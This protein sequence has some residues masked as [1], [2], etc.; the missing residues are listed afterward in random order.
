MISQQLKVFLQVVDCG[1]FTKAAGQLFVTPASIMKHMNTLEN[2]LGVTLLKRNNQGIS[3][4]SAG[5]ALYKDGKKLVAEAENAIFKAKNIE[6]GEGTVIRIGSSL[7]NP[8]RV[9]TDLWLPIQEKYKQYRFSIVPYEDKKEQILSVTSSL[10]ERIDILIGSFNSK[11]MLETANYYPLGHYK[12]CIAVPK[13]HPL[14]KKKELTL[15]DL[16][17]E[18]LMMVKSGDT[19]L[20]DHFHDMMKMTHPQIL[21]EEADYYYDMETF[22]TCERT[23][24]L[25]LTLDA[26]AD[27]HPFL[28]TLPV[29][30][31]YKIPYGILYAKN[32]SEDVAEFVKIIKQQ[33]GNDNN[34]N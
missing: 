30:L 21:I 9:L 16:H 19:E 7:L 2:R 15:R 31:D 13:G 32:P 11:K 3:L 10:G 5:K 33:F 26:W 29:S 25:L 27:I 22:N 12:F 20:I 14:A 4:T 6:C 24:V 34:L 17:G 28:I 1:S 23:G 18:R 8:S